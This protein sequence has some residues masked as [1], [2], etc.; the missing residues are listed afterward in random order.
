M[1]KT[2]MKTYSLLTILHVVV[3]Y[4]VAQDHRELER[5]KVSSAR[6]A[7]AAGE[8]YL[9]VI[10]NDSIVKCDKKSGREV[11]F[12]HNPSLKHLNSGMIKDGKLFCA[13]SNYPE[14]PMWGSIEIWDAVTLDHIGSQSLGISYGSCTWIAFYDDHY[15]VMFAHYD[16]EG[17]RQINRDVSWSQLVKFDSQWRKVQ[18]WVLPP[19]LIERLQPYSLSGGVITS[20]GKLICTHH[21]HRELY[22][23]SFP[24]FGSA[25]VWEKTIPTSICGQGISYDDFED[26]IL[27]GIC[28]D[29]KEVVKTHFK[30][31]VK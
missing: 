23:L 5:F 27:W 4:C 18:A 31:S 30:I 3:F 29:S 20:F 8:N 25:L 12:Y 6:Q 9:F 24:E 19:R 7:I 13:H 15:F 2:I 10:S 14:L 21:H 1:T 16:R 11:S 17:R 22:L 26:N 28:R